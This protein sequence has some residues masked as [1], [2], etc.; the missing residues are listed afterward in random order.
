MSRATPSSAWAHAL[1]LICACHLCA[2]GGCALLPRPL[3]APLPQEQ[4]VSQLRG[5]QGYL[6]TVTDIG[7]RLNITTTVDGNARRL[8]S[9][10]GLIAFDV[11]RLALWLRAEK[12]GREIFSLKT[13]GNLFWLAVPQTAEIV[14]GGPIAY[15]K[16]PGVFLRPAEVQT[17]FAGPDWL[18]LSWGATRMSVD[19]KNYRFDVHLLGALYRRVL[20]DRRTLA[21][22]GISRYDSL[23]RLITRVTLARHIAVDGVLFPRELI[24]ERPDSGVTVRL[25]LGNP[26]F[27]KELPL[28]TFMPE[29][30]AGYTHHNLDRESIYD[31]RFF[32]EP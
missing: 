8:P 5:S 21:V 3:P 17:F 11:E 32:N 14:T 15:S 12:L 18:G 31:I 27:N 28:E 29:D 16:L 25:R 23:G 4:V 9:L 7:L 2:G 26:K 24:V 10:G 30:R 20:V 22:T 13:I 1:L 6:R 19:G